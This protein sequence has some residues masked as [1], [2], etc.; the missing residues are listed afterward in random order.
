MFSWSSKLL[1]RVEKDRGSA[2][3]IIKY[4]A[5][6][7]QEKA[8]TGSMDQ[9][10]W[11]TLALELV[12]A[13][14]EMA[15]IFNIA[16]GLLLSLEDDGFNERISDFMSGLLQRPDPREA[17]ARHIVDDDSIHWVLTNSYSSTVLEILKA[18]HRRG[19]FKVTVAESLPMGEGAMFAEALVSCGIKIEIISDSMVFEWMDKA[20]AF[21]CGADAVGP[22]GV[23]NK[24]GSRAIATAAHLASKK[25]FV[26]CD[27]M[28]ICPVQVKKNV[29]KREPAAKDVFRSTQMF[30]TFPLELVTAVVTENGPVHEEE[31]QKMFQE[32]ELDG[33]LIS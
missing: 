8:S 22:T 20:D 21:I 29:C 1:R 14:P 19:D 23:F 12:E 7:I 25:V 15:A 9:K 26:A 10:D 11:E 24:M 3:S 27:S 2:S 31:L 18:M 33:R 13:K 28:K 5:G 4:I 6:D 17:I 30:E 32:W 16:N